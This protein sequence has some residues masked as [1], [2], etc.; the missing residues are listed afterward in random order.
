M[1]P[2]KP[3]KMERTRLSVRSCRIMRV[4][5]APN[6]VRMDISARRVIPRTRRRLAMLAQA[7]RSTR[8]EIHIRS[9]RL[10]A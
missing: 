9:L 4:R 7:M 5:A 8:P 1:R 6:A 10:E 3:L 2:A